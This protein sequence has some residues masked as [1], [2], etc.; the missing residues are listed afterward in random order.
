LKHRPGK[1]STFQ[2]TSLIAVVLLMLLVF[3]S[4]AYLFFLSNPDVSTK[5]T[6]DLQRLEVARQKWQELRPLAFRYVVEREC[7]CDDDMRLPYLAREEASGR[8]AWLGVVGQFGPDVSGEPAPQP[9]W[10]DELFDMIDTS[11]GEGGLIGA[12][13]DPRFGFPSWVQLSPDGGDTYTVRDFEVLQY[14]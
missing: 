9:V 8:S 3:V 12:R 4:A 14:D 10:I 11:L 7:A 1:K 5:Q 6:A 2:P 13:Y